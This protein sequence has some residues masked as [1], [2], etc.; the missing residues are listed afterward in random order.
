MKL[1]EGMA[2]PNYDYTVYNFF[3]LLYINII[4]YTVTICMQLLVLQLN[5]ELTSD[6]VEQLQSVT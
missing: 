1:S 2:A 3:K 5:Y 4:C 6:E